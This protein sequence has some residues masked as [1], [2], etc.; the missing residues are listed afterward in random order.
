MGFGEDFKQCCR[1]DG[2]LGA[3]FP[4]LIFILFIFALSP[5]LVPCFFISLFNEWTKSWFKD[6]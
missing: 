3:I 2:L 6:V 4:R 1:E 5:V